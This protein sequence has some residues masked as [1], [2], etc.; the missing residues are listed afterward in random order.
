LTA[1]NTLNAVEAAIVKFPKTLVVVLGFFAFSS[2]GY[3]QM[4]SPAP[5]ASPSPQV[6]VETLVCIRHGEKTSQELGQL[7]IQGLNRS[8]A[9]PKVLLSKYGRPQFIFAPNP[10]E[11]LGQDICYIRPL[12]TIEPTAILCRLPIDTQFGFKDIQALESEVRKPIYQ[13]SVVFI[14]WEHLMLEKF[15]RFLVGNLGGDT[16]KVPVWAHGDFDSI[17]VI[18]IK[19]Q[20]AKESA[21]FSLDHEGLDNLS[22]SYP[23]PAVP[24]DLLQAAPQ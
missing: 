7:D 22:N 8:L 9:L 6:S 10:A 24:E 17:Y 11:A 5:S 21:A 14:A 15:V 18:R 16:T 12:A 23:G 20:G 4:E 19:T 13:N 3:G 1:V 2:P